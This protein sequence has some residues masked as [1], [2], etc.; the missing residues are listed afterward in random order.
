M[1]VPPRGRIY[2]VLTHLSPRGG[3]KVGLS[4]VFADLALTATAA[5]EA[6]LALATAAT[7]D[8]VSYDDAPLPVL[9]VSAPAAAANVVSSVL[10]PLLALPERERE[11][12]LDTLRAWFANEGSAAKTAAA[13]F[14]HRNT[15]GYRAQQIETLTGRRLTDGR[16]AA[17]LYI[18]LEA[19]RLKSVQA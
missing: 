5:G 19:Q 13:M 9:L 1:V 16:D 11:T 10:G 15:I 18:A 6:R 3:E 14:V 17:E 4:G 12:L 8:L 2:A 7:G